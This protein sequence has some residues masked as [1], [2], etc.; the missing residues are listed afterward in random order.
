[1]PA[2]VR[3]LELHRAAAGV[4]GRAWAVS[5]REHREAQMASVLVP[6]P[7]LRWLPTIRKIKFSWKNCFSALYRLGSV[8]VQ[9]NLSLVFGD[10]TVFGPAK[11][12]RK[13]SSSSGS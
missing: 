13:S 5:T 2:K 12:A 1:M 8:N 10:R 7:L 11:R 9:G 3:P 4:G 6:S